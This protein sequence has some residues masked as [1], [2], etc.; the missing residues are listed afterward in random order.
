MHLIAQLGHL[1][2][3]TANLPVAAQ[4]AQDLLGFRI[5]MRDMDRVSLTSNRRRAEIT[6]IAAACP[7]VRSI[8][9]EAVS[10]DAV[11]EA[12]RRALSAGF[13]ILSMEP[14]VRGTEAG[15]VFQGPSGH[16][17]EV[18]SAVPRDQLPDY[19]TLGVRPARLDHVSITVRNVAETR[20]ML[21]EV[22]G[23]KLSDTADD[24]TFLFMRAADGYHHTIAVVQGEPGLHHYSLEAR[25]VGDLFRICDQLSHFNRPLVWGPGHHGANAQSYFTYYRDGDGCIVEHSYGMT[26]IA[27]ES[28]YRPQVWPAKPGPG[29]D[30]LNL[31]GVPPTD[32]FGSP[33]LPLSDCWQRARVA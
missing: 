32:M 16:A 12:H 23:M 20:D 10:V 29:E 27:N 22:L 5:S 1:T 21:S 33:G 11:K 30:W 14:T 19:M 8:G 31:W 26:K 7:A 18:H 9:L 28:I 17:F 6:Y 2:I 15:F 25:D 24:E 13:E 4:E 3:E